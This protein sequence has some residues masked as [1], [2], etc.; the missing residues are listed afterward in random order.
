[1]IESVIS[2]GNSNPIR[3]HIENDQACVTTADGRFYVAQEGQSNA[4]ASCPMCL[5]LGALGSCIMLTLNAV[6]RHKGIQMLESAVFLDYYREKN[7]N[8][9]FLV[10]LK[11]DKHLTDREHKILYGS[12]RACEVGKILKSDVQIDYHLLDQTCDS[13]CDPKAG[14]PSR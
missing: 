11:L 12:A 13:S 7:G 10:T 4:V 9:R 1:M 8:T 3:V 14:N 5:M 2:K 6:A